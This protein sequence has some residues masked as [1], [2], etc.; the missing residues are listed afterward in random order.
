MAKKDQGVKC[1]APRNRTIA[2]TDVD[3]TRLRNRL[4]VERPVAREAAPPEGVVCADYAD[5]LSLLPS[6]VV[7]L[8]FLDPPYNLTKSFNGLKFSRKSEAEYTQWLGRVLRGLVPLLKPSA[9]VYICGD[10]RTS[11]SIFEAASQHFVIQNRITWERE[12]GRGATSNWKNASEDI[13][14]CTATD[15]YYFNVDAVKLR[16]RV[17]APYTTNDGKPKDWQRT[18]NGDFRDTHPSNLWTDIS[19]PFW[20]MPEN[21]D[22]PAQKS[23][24]LLA[25]LLLASTRPDDFVLDPFLGSGTTAVVAQKLGRRCLGIEI[26]EEYCLLALRRLEMASEDSA[27]QG[28]S[29]GVFWERNTLADQLKARATAP[30][31]N[32]GGRRPAERACLFE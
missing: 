12:K 29:D 21:T 8:L 9:T 30:R 13:W 27:I 23:E 16:R 19:I 7:D 28:Y 2:L 32:A 20:S 24:K 3:R 10:W 15:E 18:T 14:F 11:H 5:W 26:D 31:S 1:R 22:H 17:L 25:K 4:L 6:G